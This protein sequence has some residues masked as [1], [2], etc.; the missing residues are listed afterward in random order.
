M[1]N[2]K[3][4]M[5]SLIFASGKPISKKR[6]VKLCNSEECK[7][8]EALKLLNDEYRQNK[9]GIRLMLKSDQVQMV[10]APEYASFV[11]KLLTSELNEDLSKVSLETLAI[12][13]YR[14]PVTRVD[15][16]SIRGVNCM[17][18]L[19]N[20]AMRGLIEKK[21]HQKDSRLA[22]YEVSANFLKHMGVERVEDLPD[23]KEMQEKMNM[24]AED[25]NKSSK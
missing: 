23:F 22:V 8:D 4:V 9:R 1:Q 18:I 5:E 19:R 3:F 20:L 17:Y 12:I 24:S 16:E 15:V 21:Q 13:A 10:T 11:E 25:N 7:V 6:L 14:G 2:L